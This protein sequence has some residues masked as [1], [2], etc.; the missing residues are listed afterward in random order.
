MH[1]AGVVV[2]VRVGCSSLYVVLALTTVGVFLC[3]MPVAPRTVMK[4]METH[5]GGAEDAGAKITRDE[6]A[7]VEPAAGSGGRF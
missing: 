4:L 7:T 6:P 1:V 3:A 2:V 5:E